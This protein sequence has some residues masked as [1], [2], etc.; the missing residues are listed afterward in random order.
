MPPARD[1]L[2]QVINRVLK[3]H[4]S[5]TFVARAQLQPLDLVSDLSIDA[6]GM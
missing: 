6:H 2:L 3:Y 4:I 1:A 5:T